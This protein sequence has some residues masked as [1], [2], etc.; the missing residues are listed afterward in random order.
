MRKLI[1][2]TCG[3]SLLTNSLSETDNPNELRKLLNQHANATRPADIPEDARSA[4][5]G[6]LDTAQKNLLAA[7]TESCK[8]LSAE[9]SGLFAL[10][11]G[12]LDTKDGLHWLIA[13]DTWLGKATATAIKSKLES[14]GATVEIKDIQDLRT[15]SLELFHIGTI[16]LARLCAQEVKGMRAGGYRVIFNLTGGFKGVQ[17]FMQALGI[18]YADESVYVFERTNELLRLPRLPFSLDAAAVLREH[19]PIFRK[20]KANLPTSANDTQGISDALLFAID[21]QYSLSAWGEVIWHEGYVELYEEA[22]HPSFDKKL[23]FADT[24][25]RSTQACSAHEKRQINERLDDLIQCLHTKNNPRRL[26]FTK[27]SRTY[28]TWTHECD[29]WAE[30]KAKRLFGHF[31]EGVFVLDTLDDALH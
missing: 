24:F 8:R 13:S 21:R 22:I 26:D 30:G 16:E 31:E 3:T 7:D 17:G 4:L 15:D 2:S 19:L 9:F 27:L 28:G 14:M 20:M 11:Q 18:I 1:L 5:Q 25:L 12:T 6:L 23:Q 10:G 29:A